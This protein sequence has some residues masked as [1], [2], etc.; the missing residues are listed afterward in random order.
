MPL[1]CENV[2]RC[3]RLFIRLSIYLFVSKGNAVDE[4]IQYFWDDSKEP[5]KLWEYTHYTGTAKTR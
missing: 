4:F 5:T 3:F 2:V 1:K